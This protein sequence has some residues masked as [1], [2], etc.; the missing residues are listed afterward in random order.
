MAKLPPGFEINQ[1]ETKHREGDRLIVEVEMKVCW[2]AWP[3]LCFDYLR[4][5]GEVRWWQWPH[6]V[7]II[8]LFWRA[9]LQEN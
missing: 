1:I 5:H 6:A 9:A 8:L 7:W 3:R 2:W 4:E